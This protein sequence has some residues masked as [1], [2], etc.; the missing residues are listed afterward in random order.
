M[1]SRKL[2][3]S[4]RVRH[5]ECPLL[6][7]GFHAE[8][9]QDG[10]KPISQR[11][12]EAVAELAEALARFEHSIVVWF[13][14]DEE[15]EEEAETFLAGIRD[16]GRVEM[17][18]PS[19]PVYYLYCAEKED[20]ANLLG[21]IWDHFGGIKIYPAQ[22][23]ESG[24]A[25]IRRAMNDKA[26][27]QRLGMDY[28]KRWYIKR[29][30]KEQRS[31]DALRGVVGALHDAGSF[32]SKLFFSKGFR[33]ELLDEFRQKSLVV[34]AEDLGVI[35]CKDGYDSYA[36][37]Q[38]MTSHHDALEIIRDVLDRNGVDFE[39]KQNDQSY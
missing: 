20:L 8:A 37:L 15:A 5:G 34:P 9:D 25:Y 32:A 16:I 3:V 1:I 7:A 13:A 22:N 23:A 27:Q 33:R 38:I 30:R 36:F 35:L 14:C 11:E 12:C 17:D 10:M 28:E 21:L 18:G 4:Y 26:D 19:E 6:S 29:S 31:S 24:Y 2:S 39:T